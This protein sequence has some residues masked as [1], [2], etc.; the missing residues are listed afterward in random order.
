MG[1]FF[2]HRNCLTNHPSKNQKLKTGSNKIRYNQI[3]TKIWYFKNEE[4]WT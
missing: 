2:V 1:L 3:I 4:E